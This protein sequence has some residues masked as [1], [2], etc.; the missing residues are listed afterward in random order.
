LFVAQSSFLKVLF[1]FLVLQA[2]ILVSPVPSF[3]FLC[4]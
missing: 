3:L 1:L 2:T 4:C